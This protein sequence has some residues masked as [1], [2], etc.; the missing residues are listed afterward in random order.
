MPSPLQDLRVAV[1]GGSI[2]GLAAAVALQR[3]GAAV[4]VFEKGTQS[5][6]G[7]GGSMGYCDVPLWNRL[8]GQ[9]MLRRGVPAH[10]S[11]GAYLYGDLWRFWMEALRPETV[12]FG[13]EVQDLGDDLAAP[14][15]EGKTYELAVVADGGFSSLRSRLFD[16]ATPRY[17]GY[18]GWRFRVKAEHVPGWDSEGMYE[19][20]SFRSI[21]MTIAQDDGT[22]W[23]MGGTLVSAPES[24]AQAAAES[25]RAGANRQ[26]SGSDA[27][28]VPAWFLPFYRKHFGSLRGG[29]LYRAME[30]AATF[31]KI[32][33]LPQYEFA[34]S[35]VVNGHCVLVG[36]A[37]HMA[38]PMTAAGAHTA[39]LDAVGLLNA[40]A[41]T[42]AASPHA[43][44]SSL[45]DRALAAYQGPA[46]ERAAALYAR[47]RA[48][49]APVAV[50]DER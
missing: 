50:P 43:T 47:S 19:V 29:E 35:R 4:E 20:G 41:T 46:L 31:G 5:Y 48:L 37:A 12:H 6:H 42:A 8:R 7:R 32:A 9:T 33:P 34:T 23:L 38:S 15:V 17:A 14:R 26:T 10:R 1:V 21:L 3:L 2:G 13:V 22:D 24:E 49:S 16:P 40:F 36:D 18:I 30:A 44:A 11:Q 45:I 27:S 25:T 28:T 39:V